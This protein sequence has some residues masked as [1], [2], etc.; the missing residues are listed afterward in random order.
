[1]IAD[2]LRKGI[3]WARSFFWVSDS[4]DDRARSP[5]PSA[6]DRATTAPSGGQDRGHA[7]AAAN[8][9]APQPASEPSANTAGRASGAAETAAARGS[10]TGAAGQSKSSTGAGAKGST[11]RK[12][13]GPKRGGTTSA[14]SRG[15]AQQ[16]SVRSRPG[17]GK[18]SGPGAPEADPARPGDLTEI[19]GIGPAMK[20]KLHDLGIKNFADLAG[21][22]PDQL[23][24][25]LASRPITPERVRGWIAEAKKRS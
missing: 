3:D 10:A 4:D 21:A 14:A 17:G 5:Q 15:G 23:A 20:T 19:K 7:A 22:D 8:T 25:S 1:M 12:S 16:A 2:L 11:A 9:P 24:K 6:A 18:S 13:G